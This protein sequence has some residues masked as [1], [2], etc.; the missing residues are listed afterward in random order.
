MKSGFSVKPNLQKK[1]LKTS[2]KTVGGIKSPGRLFRLIVGLL[3]ANGGNFKISQ[4]AIF[5]IFQKNRQNIK[6]NQR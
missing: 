6:K 4:Y 5:R 2:R 1:G 3:C